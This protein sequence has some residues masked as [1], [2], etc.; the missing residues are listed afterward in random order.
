MDKMRSDL[1]VLHW[2]WPH[3]QKK[4]DDSNQRFHGLYQPVVLT[5]QE[6]L[7]SSTIKMAALRY[8]YPWGDEEFKLNKY[9]INYI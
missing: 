6:K 7:L 2:E 1:Q 3:V 9:Y 5:T 8:A 4:D